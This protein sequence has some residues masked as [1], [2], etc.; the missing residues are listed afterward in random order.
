MLELVKLR[1]WEGPTFPELSFGE[2]LLQW[3]KPFQK[4]KYLL[5]YFESKKPL[6]LNYT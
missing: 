4:K 2:L 5:L 6:I 1:T 3:G